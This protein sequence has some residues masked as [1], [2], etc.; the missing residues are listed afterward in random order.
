MPLYT[1]SAS[2]ASAAQIDCTQGPWTPGVIP[3]QPGSARPRDDGALTLEAQVARQ[4]HQI[5][6]DALGRAFTDI[7]DAVEAAW[8]SEGFLRMDR[9]P[10]NPLPWDSA[11]EGAHRKWLSHYTDS[12]Q[13]ARGV[14][15]SHVRDMDTDRLA[16]Y[17]ELQTEARALIGQGQRMAQQAALLH[18]RA[19][20]K[21][22][23]ARALFDS[24]PLWNKG[25]P[26]N[27][28]SKAPERHARDLAIFTMAG[29]VRPQNA[30]S[31]ENDC[32]DIL[33]PA[34]ASLSKDLLSQLKNATQQNV[35]FVDAQQKVMETILALKKKKKELN[36]ADERGRTR[37]RDTDT[38]TLPDKNRDALE[39]PMQYAGS[40]V[41]TIDTKQGGG[42]LQ[43]AMATLHPE[44]LSSL[45][46]MLR[47]RDTI[48]LSPLTR[49]S[50]KS[51]ERTVGPS[52]SRRRDQDGEG[53]PKAP[54]Q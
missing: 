24:R 44:V 42:D 3:P 15:I 27:K 37:T 53:S 31:F 17:D 10:G 4:S 32:A 7:Q 16:Q 45:I 34:K 5:C 40:A 49:Q 26:E 25:S 47:G 54:H 9:N 22:K 13:L 50:S 20:E 41:R 35:I 28:D 38:E 19:N 43:D 14:F 51:A 8:V 30:E 36:A 21:E 33:S 6:R 52:S 48:L 1:P 11:Q 39:R 23:A 2:S 29:I 46:H 12:Q 18:A